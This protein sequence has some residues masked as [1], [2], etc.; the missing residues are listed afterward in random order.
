ME[1]PD[2]VIEDIR[3]RLHRV[4]GQLAGIERMLDD[5]RECKD[6]VSQ[7]SAATRAL[8]QAGFKLLAAGLTY[9]VSHPDEAAAAGYPLEA[10]EKMFLK[11]A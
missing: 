3:R 1:I 10:M 7:I 4:S 6:V 5:G 8:E 11:L 2:D 9:C